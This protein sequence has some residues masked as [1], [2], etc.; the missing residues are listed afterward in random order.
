MGYV[1]WPQEVEG[2]EAVLAVLAVVAVVAVA[3]WPASSII[4]PEAHKA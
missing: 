4:A 3:F 1:V 2:P